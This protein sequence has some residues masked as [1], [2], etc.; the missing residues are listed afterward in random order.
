MAGETEQSARS[1]AQRAVACSAGRLIA[2]NLNVGDVKR[3]HEKD[4]SA[5]A[6]FGVPDGVGT[7]GTNSLFAISTSILVHFCGAGER[8]M[9]VESAEAGTALA[10]LL[11]IALAA[12]RGAV[13]ARGQD[14]SLRSA[15]CR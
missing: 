10:V 9:G 14:R 12:N 8:L 5:R 7:R 3:R 15:G 4:H 2:A 6:V 13:R 1:S 11:Y